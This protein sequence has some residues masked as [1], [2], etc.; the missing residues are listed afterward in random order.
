VDNVIGGQGHTIPHFVHE[1]AKKYHRGII[2]SEIVIKRNEMRHPQIHNPIKS[3]LRGPA[4]E[5]IPISRRVAKI[6]DVKVPDHVL[7]IPLH[8]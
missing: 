6:I 8:S 4:Y 7:N 1:T 2:L 5:P 3:L